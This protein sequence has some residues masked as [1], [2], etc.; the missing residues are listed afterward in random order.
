MNKIT[1][2]YKYCYIVILLYCYIVVKDIV[3]LYLEKNKKSG[4][5]VIGLEFFF[6]KK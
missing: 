4:E 5:V 1:N 2:Y 6:E 3:C